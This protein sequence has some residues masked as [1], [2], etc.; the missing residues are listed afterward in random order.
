MKPEL[1]GIP[2]D[3]GPGKGVVVNRLPL[4][5]AGSAMLFCFVVLNGLKHMLKLT[6]SLAIQLLLLISFIF[7]NYST[8]KLYVVI[9]N[10][11]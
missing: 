6:P 8:A 11:T 5:C 4:V 2:S 1:Y 10:Y 7:L 3:A 9:Q